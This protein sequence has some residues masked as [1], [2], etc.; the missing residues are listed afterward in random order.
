MQIT[1]L[2]SFCYLRRYRNPYE[3]DACSFATAV[4]SL[5]IVLITSALLPVDIFLVSSMKNQDGSF[6]AWAV[7]NST[8]QNVE[9]ALLYTYYSLYGV[10][11][12]LIFGVIPFVYFYFEEKNDDGFGNENRLCSAFKFTLGFIFVAVVLLLIGA[13][14][15]LKEI[16]NAQNSTDWDNIKF[17][18]SDLG[19]NRGEDSI[20][21]VLSI[22]S[23]F[24]MVNLVFYTGFGIF[25]WPMGMI[26]G[27]KSARNQIE[28]IQDQHLVNQTRINALRD[29]ERLGGRLT[30]R[31]KRLLAT[32]EDAERDISREE[33]AVDEHQQSLSYKLRVLLR[34]MEVTCGAL[35]GLL[36]MLIWFSLLLTK[37]VD[38]F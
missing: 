16:P 9:N 11:F 6:Q 26:R 22:L 18:I 24:G 27:T 30:T 25:S 4:I 32:L 20:S 1:S 2:F 34:P 28:E 15:P 36:G 23:V 14:V 37:L 33:Q 7:E 21:M 17:L 5:I 13:F 12:G 19:K 31:E 3:K 10:I 38:L 35:L 8:R 29:K